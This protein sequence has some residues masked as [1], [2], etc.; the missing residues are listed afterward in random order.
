MKTP[1]LQPK[2]RLFSVRLSAPRAA[3]QAP[4]DA[5]HVGKRTACLYFFEFELPKIGPWL[6]A[7]VSESDLIGALSHDSF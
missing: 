6:A 5:F 1:T 7:A 2:W 3:S 4:A